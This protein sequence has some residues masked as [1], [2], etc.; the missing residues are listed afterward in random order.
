MMLSSPGLVFEG[1]DL[2]GEA[3]CIMWSIPLLPHLAASNRGRK[4]EPASREQVEF[5]RT[6]STKSLSGPVGR[7]KLSDKLTVAHSGSTGLRIAED[8]AVDVYHL[9]RA[10]EELPEMASA[11]LSG[12]RG[13]GAA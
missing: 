8:G 4:E 9:P 10:F 2:G 12:F 7:R 5:R 13:E 11:A 3:G 1:S 6:Q